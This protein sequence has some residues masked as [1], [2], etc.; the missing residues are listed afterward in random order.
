MTSWLRSPKWSSSTRRT[1]RRFVPRFEQL[2][3]RLALTGN[4]A[5]IVSGGSL[6][7]TGSNLGADIYVSQPCIGQIT[8]T[9]G[10]TAVNGST[11]PITFKG[12]TRDLIINFVGKGD[13]SIT[14]DEINP[15]N[16]FGNLTINGGQ[17]SN[18]VSVATSSASLNFASLNVG[19]NLS[20]LNLPALQKQPT[21]ST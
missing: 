17:G 10:D 4:V 1:Y 5:A 19:G 8:L 7:V 3:P 2:E 15:I 6:I 18:T 11:E 21:C 12:V 20:I 13:D 9:S 16:L 14:F